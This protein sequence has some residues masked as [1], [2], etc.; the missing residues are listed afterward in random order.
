MKR[1]LVL[2][3]VT[4]VVVVSTGA[5][6]AQNTVPPSASTVPAAISTKAVRSKTEAAPLAGKN[7]FTR[8]EA[9]RRIAANGYSKVEVGNVDREGIWRAKAMK[10]GRSVDI[11]LDYQGNVVEQ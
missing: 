11:A 3:M 2:V 10:D 7:S 8:G 6:V 4:A 1:A 9:A 5:V